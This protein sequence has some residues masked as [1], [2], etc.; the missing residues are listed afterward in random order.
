MCLLMTR[1]GLWCYSFPVRCRMLLMLGVAGTLAAQVPSQQDDP[2]VR[3]REAVEKLS[4]VFT[5]TK[6]EHDKAR[7]AIAALL[8]QRL[9][10]AQTAS[11]LEAICE[12]A[13]DFW[14]GGDYAQPLAVPAARKA[15]KLDPLRPAA[16]MC[17]AM[18][19][20]DQAEDEIARERNDLARRSWDP[21]WYDGP[22]RK[23]RDIFLEAERRA[24]L[25]IANKKHPIWVDYANLANIQQE[26]K[27]R[28]HEAFASNRR[29]LAIAQRAKNQIS[30]LLVL[31][32]LWPQALTIG[33]RAQAKRYFAQLTEISSDP[34]H[35]L[36]YA[37]RMAG[38]RDFEEA[39]RAY[40]RLAQLSPS[41][42]KP[43]YFTFAA[44]QYGLASRQDDAL[45]AARKA[46]ALAAL[47][48]TE[49]V[50]VCHRLIGEILCERG[51]YEE[52]LLHA[53]E[54]VA[55][56]GGD[57]R[58]YLLLARALK[59]LH[60]SPEAIVA[61]DAA[62][63]IS[64]GRDAGVHFLRGMIYFDMG[65][66]ADAAEAFKHAAALDTTDAASTFNIALCLQNEGF[67]SDAA[68][69]FQETLRRDPAHPKR[70]E[71]ERHIKKV[72]AQ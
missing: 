72:R 51:V 28:E 38:D 57:Y 52:A 13:R 60:R 61:A 45:D 65:Q 40:M 36:E 41:A 37:E 24:L 30:V 55:A 50:S 10:D 22:A 16:N 23:R 8:R 62:L 48:D 54:A 29:A 66:W 64:E 4:P 33:E 53:R 32:N 9:E 58:G 20:W 6:Q 59:G 71:L 34:N 49:T 31:E 3:L 21:D 18:A 2:A 35:W 26:I 56:N 70:I 1:D 44:I 27:G 47:T 17:L 11:E 12:I 43:R 14:T 69:W 15:V 67:D 25:A 7:Q 19:L 42:E 5:A 63:K 39:G 46:L 68:D